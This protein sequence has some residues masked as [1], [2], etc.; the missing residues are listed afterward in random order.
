MSKLTNNLYIFLF[1][2]SALLPICVFAQQDTQVLKQVVKGWDV[3]TGYFFNDQPYAKTGNGDK[4]LVY[5]EELSFDHKPPE[6][7]LLNINTNIMAF[8]KKGN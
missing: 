5:I 8:L 4:V 2:I 3:E 1:S 6:E 7:F